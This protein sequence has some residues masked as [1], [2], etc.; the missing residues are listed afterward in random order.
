MKR[1][2]TLIEIVLVVVL[3][4]VLAA[5]AMSNYMAIKE[6]TLNR[7]A[8]A[9]LQLIRAAERNYRMEY[10]NYYPYPATTESTISVINRDLKL[11]LPVSASTGWLISLNRT[12]ES[13]TATRVGADSR[14]WT[15]NFSKDAGDPTC[16]AGTYTYCSP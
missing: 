13:A 16:P 11:N 3:V 14:I 15:I 5:F 4:G 9:M 6:K 8:K 12:A 2:F 7:Q 1:G 10:N